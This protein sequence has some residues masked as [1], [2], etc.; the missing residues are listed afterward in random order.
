MR[1]PNRVLASLSFL[2]FCALQLVLPL[3]EGVVLS[4]VMDCC[5]S[6]S[7]LDLPYTFDAKDG[8]LEMVEGGAPSLVTKKKNFNVKKASLESESSGFRSNRVEPFCHG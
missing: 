1:G 6:G 4:V 2:V 3:P 8:A 5:H 7:I